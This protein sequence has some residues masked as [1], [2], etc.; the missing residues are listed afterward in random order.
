MGGKMRLVVFSHRESGL[1]L[2][3]FVGLLS[4]MS[5]QMDLQL[6]FSVQSSLAAFK[7]ARI[8]ISMLSLEME[9]QGIIFEASRF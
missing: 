4:V 5:P 3:T 2:A 1:A 8:L 9:S 7:S 6:L